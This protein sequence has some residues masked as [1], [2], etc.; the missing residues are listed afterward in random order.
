MSAF[1]S[2]DIVA[3]IMGAAAIITAWA[4]F[5]R[6]SSEARREDG[7]AVESLSKGAAE[8]A[9]TAQ[10]IYESVIKR[11]DVL[12]LEVEELTAQNATLRRQVGVLKDSEEALIRTTMVQEGR[13]QTLEFE[14]KAWREF[15]EALANQLSANGITPVVAAPSK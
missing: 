13:I 8:Q 10:K 11:I 1:T 3:L 15:G 2:A 5:R 7:S 12:E 9:E 4:A 14:S 6:S